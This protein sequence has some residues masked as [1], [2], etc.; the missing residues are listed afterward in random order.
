MICEAAITSPIGWN[1]RAFR[2]TLIG[3]LR[4]TTSDKSYVEIYNN[5]NAKVVQRES[6]MEEELA[7]GFEHEQAAWPPMTSNRFYNILTLKI[8]AL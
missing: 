2:K 1:E 4:Q 8:D 3:K 5:I 6:D 7:P